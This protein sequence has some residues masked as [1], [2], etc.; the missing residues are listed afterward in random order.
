MTYRVVVRTG[1]TPAA[2]FP[3]AGIGRVTIQSCRS[4]GGSV[5]NFEGN[6]DPAQRWNRAFGDSVPGR[7]WNRDNCA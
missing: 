2:A 1:L 3:V 4:N 7:P 5:L 6:K